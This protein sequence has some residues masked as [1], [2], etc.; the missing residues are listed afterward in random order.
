MSR[1]IVVRIT[2]IDPLS[3]KAIEKC[4]ITRKQS[5]ILKE[6]LYHYVRSSEG[7]KSLSM[8]CGEI[9]FTPDNCVK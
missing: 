1:S 3:I 5:Q 8:C 7:K 2:L 9:I 4:R 6:A